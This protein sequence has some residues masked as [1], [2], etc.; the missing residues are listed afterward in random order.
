MPTAI[1]FD[2]DGLLF[3]TEALYQE[4]VLM[5]AA[6]SGHDAASGIFSRTIGLPW[7]QVRSLLLDHYGAPFPVD[8]FL[9]AWQRH[10]DL[11]AADRLTLT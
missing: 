4:A 10:F 1:I 8:E 11:I 5:A 2:M 9:A 6:E 3:D 7:Q